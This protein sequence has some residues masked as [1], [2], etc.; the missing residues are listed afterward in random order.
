MP[1]VELQRKLSAE[2]EEFF[3][4]RMA[5]HGVTTIE[6][7]FDEL[8]KMNM[9]EYATQIDCPTLRWSAR[10]TSSAVVGRRSWK[11]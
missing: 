8:R 9:L 11:P 6:E 3:G 2:R 7:Y 4:A 5:A 1:V 10:A